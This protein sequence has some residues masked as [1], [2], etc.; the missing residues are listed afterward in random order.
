L[1]GKVAFVAISVPPGWD[2]IDKSVEEGRETSVTLLKKLG[3]EV[4]LDEFVYD[5]E[6]AKNV[7]FKLK[8]IDFDLLVLNVL[9]WPGGDTI[10]SFIQEVPSNIPLV[11]WTF[12]TGI[13]A[14]TGYY[15]V[16]SDLVAVRRGFKPIIG[17][18]KEA[19]EEMKNYMKAA[20]LAKRLK[21][22]KIGQIGY[23]PPAFIDATGSEREL[24]EKLGISIAHLDVSEVFREIDKVD[25]RSAEAVISEFKKKVGKINVSNEDLVKSA[26]ISVALD[27]IV[28]KYKLSAYALR[29]QPELKDYC[30]PC[31]G[32]IRLSDM[33]IPGACEGDLPAAVTMV[34]LQELTGNPVAV[35][36][37]YSADI[38]KGLLALYH[39]GQLPTKMAENLT[40]ITV[41]RPTF[42]GIVTGI[43]AV[44]PFPAKPG[45]VTLAKLDTDGSRLFVTT[46]NVV[47]PISDYPAGGAYTEVKLDHDIT[48]TLRTMAIKGVGHHLCL[49]HGDIKL[50]LEDL[51]EILKIE[52]IM[53]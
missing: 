28:K 41:T 33:G 50:E 20:T 44:L 7:A 38:D 30:H 36:D 4:V 42:Y 31:L 17:R 5:A 34:I 49:V 51:C 27:K 16:T 48:E 45:R 10:L 46:G 1:S 47:K 15:E 26:K 2:L 12:L 3:A 21:T 32:V 40:G 19:L 14:L 52:P 25:E 6:S 23:A 8:Q 13:F 11:L 43:G 35:F 24:R 29:C 9:M 18:S 22:M 37:I 39:C 53:C